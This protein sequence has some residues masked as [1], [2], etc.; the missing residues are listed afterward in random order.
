[1]LSFEVLCWLISFFVF[2]CL[3]AIAIN[4]IHE[5][6][7]GSCLQ[8]IKMGRKCNG[9]IFYKINPEFFEKNRGK[10]WANPLWGCV[11][12]MASVYSGLTFWPVVIGIFG[13]ELWE[14]GVW[15]IDAFCLVYLNYFF[16]SKI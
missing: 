9:N 1:M 16:Y 6:F 2:V 8:D 4:G 13:F 15:A 11:K 14:I 3:Q 7:K 10:W 5:C 12:C